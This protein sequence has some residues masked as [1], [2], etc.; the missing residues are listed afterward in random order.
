MIADVKAPLWIITDAAG[1]IQDCSPRAL[2]LLGYSGRGA[3]GRELP[4][5]FITERPRLSELLEAAGGGTISRNARLRPYERRA[6]DVAFTIER[7]DS[8]V[9]RPLLRWTFVARW[10]MN[11][12]IPR[13]VDRKQL[14]TMWRAGELRCVFV[15]GGRDKR[16][17]LVCAK[18]EVV[19]E[20][21]PA[22]AVTA[23][24]RAA[25]LQRLAA[26]GEL[27]TSATG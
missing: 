6:V 17:L 24:A 1:F 20:E 3:R 21:V 8:E 10:P 19:L 15:P 22:D 12:R 11:L 5:M 14:I 25:E 2:E 18:D 16:R 9:T 13:G 27:R 23:L 4:N 7:T 26:S